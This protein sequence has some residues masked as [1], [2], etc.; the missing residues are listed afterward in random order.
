M[1]LPSGPI[2]LLGGARSGKSAFAVEL[3][4]RA[5]ADGTPVV[6]VATATAL[7]DDM[8]ARIDRHRDE[9]PGW[10]TIEEPVELAAALAATPPGHLVIVDCLTLWVSNLMLAG[11]DEAA[12][13]QR[14][15]ELAAS[16]AGRIGTSRTG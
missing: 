7:D 12:I 13:D 11:L 4:R 1:H 6:F 3:G 10:P 14:A 15:T 16:V 9:R 5:E 8:S 2:L